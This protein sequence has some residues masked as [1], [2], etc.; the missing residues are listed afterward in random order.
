[1]RFFLFFLLSAV[2]ISCAPSPKAGPEREDGSPDFSVLPPGAA[3]YLWTDIA[4]AR[5]LLEVLSFEGISGGDVSQIMDRTD[6]VLAA[7]YPEGAARR[8]FL[9][10]WG[11]YPSFGAGFFMSFSRDWKR[12][13]SVTGN[14]YWHSSRNN[15]G[16][17]IGPRLAFVSDGDPFSPGSGVNPAPSGFEELRR[18]C[19]LSGWLNDP[20]VSINRF[21]SGIG[22]PLRIP[23]EDFFFGAVRLPADYNPANNTVDSNQPDAEPAGQAPWELVFKIRASSA[24]QA[25]SFAALISTA[26][27]FMQRGAGP[28]GTPDGASIG[29]QEAV[30]L[31]FANPPE[32]D[33]AF[34]T[35]RMSPLDRNRIALL[36]S[37][38][39]LY[40]N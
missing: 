13:K 29:P 22:I 27:L 32:Q 26:R 37:M 25:R 4:H 7:F 8:F 19:V 9:V 35:L 30:E 18:S 5:P 24:S 10:G 28:A 2:L 20:S 31:L 39:S 23:A 3:L 1:V 34:I 33:G 12:V 40:S 6:T 17:A 21:I 15:L 36:F 16:I 14:R 11:N 38:F